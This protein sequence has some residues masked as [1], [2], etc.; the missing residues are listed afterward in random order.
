M[1]L[2]YEKY[3]EDSIDLEYE[4]NK[5]NAEIIEETY[6]EYHGKY[7]DGESIAD[8]LEDGVKGVIVA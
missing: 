4:R 2:R 7:D 1:E 5:T 3:F 8:M 6:F